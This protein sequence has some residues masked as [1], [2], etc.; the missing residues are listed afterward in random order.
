MDN[1]FTTPS[2]AGNLAAVEKLTNKAICNICFIRKLE[3]DPD[4]NDAAENLLYNC[5]LCDTDRVF[6]QQKAKG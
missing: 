4:A 5:K 3:D 6:S 1:V 2:P